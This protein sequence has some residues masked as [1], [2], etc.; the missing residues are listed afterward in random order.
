MKKGHPQ[1]SH[2]AKRLAEGTTKAM[3]LNCLAISLVLSLTSVTSS[4]G[5]R[6]EREPQG[7]GEF[8]D[9]KLTAD[10]RVGVF[11]FYRSVPLPDEYAGSAAIFSRAPRELPV[12][13]VIGR[14]YIGTYDL[15]T[16]LIKILWMKE[17]THWI[18][19]GYKIYIHS[20]AGE[21]ALI[22]ELAQPR[23][24]YRWRPNEYSLLD[25]KSGRLKSV[26]LLQE[27]ARR[28]SRLQH[29]YLIDPDGTLLIVT[30]RSNAPEFLDPN[31]LLGLWVRY[32][33]GKYVLLDK[34]TYFY[35]NYS[36]NGKIYYSAS[37]GFPAPPHKGMKVYD[38]KKKTSQEI[39][40]RSVSERDYPDAGLSVDGLGRLVFS[41]K[42]KD[43][44]PAKWEHKT[45]DV[46]TDVLK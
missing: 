42:I 7:R 10:G 37:G 23:R 21:T 36:S 1:I 44:H 41:W 14:T 6:Q 19:D 12:G 35:R 28:R 33:S 27:L 15:Q 22:R 18:L 24:P 32:P 3:K 4:V 30:A 26:P 8:I 20:L 39:D 29:V 9:A 43:T 25:I 46:N 45:L 16:G 34:A 11:S 31:T 2:Y 17:N 5:G 38:V 13:M 40:Y